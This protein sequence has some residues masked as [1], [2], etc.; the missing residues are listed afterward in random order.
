VSDEDVP[1]ILVRSQRDGY[2]ARVPALGDD[3]IFGP[4]LSIRDVVAAAR[5]AVFSHLRAVL[6]GPFY[7]FGPVVVASGTH[8]EAG[9]ILALIEGH[10]APEKL[11]LSGCYLPRIN[12]GRT[13]L[14]DE[15]ARWRADGASGEPPWR[16]VL[17]EGISLGSCILHATYLNGANLEGADLTLSNL[18]DVKLINANL[19]RTL[20]WHSDL[21]GAYIEESWFRW[22][23]FRGTHLQG[24]DLYD[25]HLDNAFWYGAILDKTRMRRERLGRAIGEELAAKGQRPLRSLRSSQTFHHAREAYLALKTNF[26]SIGRYDDAAWA[27]VKERQMDKAMHF[28]TTVGHGWIRSELRRGTRRWR[29]RNP[30]R[31][32]R[33]ARSSIF[34][35]VRWAWLHLRVLIRLCPPD[36]KNQTGEEHVDRPRWLRTWLYEAICGYGENAWLPLVWAVVVVAVFTAIYAAAGN[37]ASGDGGATHNVLTALTHSIAAFA[38]VGFNTLE[39]VG[40]GARLLTAIE[41]MFGIGLFA[42]FVF[43]LGNRMR[44]S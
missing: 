13:A 44:R 18:T 10:G 28:P 12:L 37:V 19:D 3:A 36:V 31:L 7:D 26:D 23:D 20:L 34:G 5:Q 17:N 1:P 16:S 35:R 22:A 11:D 2:T 27:Y 24:V 42:L 38:T 39:P 14:E 9:D 32:R 6:P 40:W 29:K 8:L 25:A 21:T 33:F 15:L 4:G 43:T 41:A 30:G